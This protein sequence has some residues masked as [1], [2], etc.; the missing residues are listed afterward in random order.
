MTIKR[1]KNKSEWIFKLVVILLFIACWGILAGVNFSAP[2]NRGIENN[3]SFW[4]N[5][6]DQ[7]F[8]PEEN[9]SEAE[10]PIKI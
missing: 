2:P 5:L 7:L 4:T 1:P 6:L 8:G 9:K 3:P 10:K